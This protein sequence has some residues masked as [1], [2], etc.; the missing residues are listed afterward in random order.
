M[1]TSLEMKNIQKF[2]GPLHVVKD[3]DLQ[4]QPGE[5]VTFLGPSGSGKTTALKMIAGFERPTSGDIFLGSRSIVDLPAYDR[6]IGMVFQNY[7]LFPHMTV[8]ENVAFPLTVRRMP[9]QEADEK[10]A[11]AIRLV[12][13]DQYCTRY[14]NQLSGGQ[15]QRIALARAIVFN[16][17]ILLMDEPLGALDRNLREHMKIEIMRIQKELN[18]TVVFVTHDQDEALTMSD[19]IAVMN[20]GRLV[21]V[22]DS[23]TLYGKPKNR[24][25]ASFVGESNM[26][27]CRVD[28]VKNGTGKLLV[29]G[30]AQGEALLSGQTDGDKGWMFVRPEHVEI[31]PRLTAVELPNA[32]NGVIENALFLGEMTR[33]LVRC[34]DETITVKRQ[35]RGQT[36]LERGT[37]VVVSWK[38]EDCTVLS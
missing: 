31:G 16:P 30:G 35:N 1:S 18:M 17:S 34:G 21:Q 24:F 13:M 10:V 27:P 14:P 29:A 5:F 15:Q 36:L 38:A 25:V 7:A 23:R 33:Y 6:G 19:R 12:K 2:Y 9:Q 11:R 22:D 37:E 32:L 26:I 8:A 4:I 3:F 28:R 20:E